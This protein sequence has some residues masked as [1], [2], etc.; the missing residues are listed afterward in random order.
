V[1]TES[2]VRHWREV[3][4]SGWPA[5]DADEIA[6]LYA[7]SAVFRSHPFR[8]ARE[9][10]S[11]VRDYAEWSFS[12]QDEAECRFG[13]PVWEGDRAAVEY[14]AVVSFQG[15]DETI[16]GTSMLRFGPDGLVTEQRDCWNAQEGRHEPPEGWGR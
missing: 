16:V 4:L 9:G 12:E 6:A 3:W 2:A 7:G 14:W 10:A 11:G 5:K 13:E 8:E 15:R 1:N